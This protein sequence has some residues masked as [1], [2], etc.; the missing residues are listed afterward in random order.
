MSK[1]N[2]NGFDITIINQNDQEYI[3]LSE[4]VSGHEDGSKLIERWMNTKSTVDFLGVWEQFY[5]P[6]FI[7]E[8]FKAIREE[9]GSSSFFLSIK[10]WIERTK[11]IG[12]T[13]KTGRYGGTFA[14]VDIALEFGSYISPEFKLLMITEFKKLKEAEAI[15][16]KWDVRRY[17]SKVN[18]K[19]QTD[20]IKSVL[21][22]LKNIPKEKEGWVYAE[23][24]DLLYYAMF[25]YTSKEWRLNNPDLALRNLNIRDVANTHQLIILANL[26]SLN[27]TLIRN[28]MSV[29]DRLIMLRKEA[30]SQLT[31]L[32]SSQDLNHELI[33]SATAAQKVIK[34]I[35]D[36]KFDRA[37]EA[38][39]KKD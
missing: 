20:A 14:H 34:S 23:E 22:P 24:A 16:G 3:C 19:L 32:K 18:Y 13:A 39:K 21:I 6:K 38:A 30:I 10:K 1:I 17:I 33:E 28:G 5:N 12:V 26:E 2:I 8:E 37:I 36:N 27:S 7:N 25:G 35:G 11:A 9:V 29:E 4:M 15:D 31:S